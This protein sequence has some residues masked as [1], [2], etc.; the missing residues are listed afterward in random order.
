MD[1]CLFTGLGADA[2]EALRLFNGE[3]VICLGVEGMAAVATVGLTFA[4]S[5]GTVAVGS[6][7]VDAADNGAVGAELSERGSLGFL[8]MSL[9]LL[10]W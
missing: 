8:N 6:G 9:M 4:D 10:L 2:S 5:D 3:E 7:C 1:F